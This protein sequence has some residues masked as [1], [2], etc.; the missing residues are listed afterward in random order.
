MSGT[1]LELILLEH[2]ESWWQ[3]LPLVL[4]GTGLLA[5]CVAALRANRRTLTLLR[6]VMSLCILAGLVGLYLHYQGNVE[7]ELEMSPALNGWDLVKAALMGA[8]PALAPGSMTQ[9]G[10]LGW[11]FTYQ[12]PALQAG[13]AGQIR[14]GEMS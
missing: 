11:A 1:L 4:L 13:V 12:H 3:W 5:A 10:L 9:L 14:S 7:F 2:T 8:T 6:L